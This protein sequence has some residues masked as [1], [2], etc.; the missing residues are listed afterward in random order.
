MSFIPALPGFTSLP[1]IT[2]ILPDIGGRSCTVVSPKALRKVNWTRVPRINMRIR[3]DEFEPMIIQMTQGWPYVFRISNRDDR[4]H[5]FN[6][7]R[8]L[9]SMA[10]TRIAI[11][12]KRQDDNCVSSVNIPAGKT[13][14][15]QM[16]AAIDGHFE[17]RDSWLPAP[18]L[19]SGGPDGVIIVEE[20][21][22][23]IGK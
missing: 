20:R 14:E 11:D 1:S 13:A 3:N 21:V 16:V 9:K 12:G 23:G 7:D 8:F 2:D 22:A 5:T 6:A 17:F 4:S 18:S 10:V 15:L 19:L